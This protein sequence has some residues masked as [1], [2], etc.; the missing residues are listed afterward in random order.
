MLEATPRLHYNGG[1]HGSGDGVGDDGLLFRNGVYRDAFG[2]CR[3]SF[4]GKYAGAVKLQVQV[5]V[6]EE[7]A[8]GLSVSGSVSGCGKAR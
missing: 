4:H 3:E 8:A 7:V 1:G 2:G 5:G 6:V